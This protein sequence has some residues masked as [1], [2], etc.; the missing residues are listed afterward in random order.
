[1]KFFILYCFGIAIIAALKLLK[2]FVKFQFCHI[3]TSRIGHQTI[4]F[5]NTI[6]SVPENTFLLCSHDTKV[7]N[8]F[9]LSIFKKQKNVFFNKIFKYIYHA[10]YAINS[11]SD[12]IISW[13]QYQPKFCFYSKLKSK[14]TLPFCL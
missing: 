2:Y 10:I 12:L 6:L 11:S 7:A 3:Y 14:I 1:M 9:I 8:K 4:N 5:D 13:D